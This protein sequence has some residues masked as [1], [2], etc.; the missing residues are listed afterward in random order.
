MIKGLISKINTINLFLVF[1]LVNS[2]CNLNN[3][4]NSS[5]KIR[6]GYLLNITHAVPMILLEQSDFKD[7]L[8]TYHFSAG[9]YLLNNLLTKNLDLAFIGPGPYLTAIDKGFKLKLLGAYAYGANVFVIS[10]DVLDKSKDHIK[11][12]KIAIPQF[13]NTQDLLAKLYL[14]DLAQDFYAI[15]PAE[16]EFAFHNKSIDATLVTEPWGSMLLDKGYVDGAKIF[17][18]KLKQINQYPTTLLVVREEYYE[19][20]KELVDEFTKESIN[21]LRKLAVVKNQQE[22]APLIQRHFKDKVKKDIPLKSIENNLK[23]IVFDEN[24]NLDFFLKQLE[25]TAYKAHYLK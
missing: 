19:A 11:D 13:G 14:K 23:T 7:K 25:Q 16:L 9:G 21:V 1:I 6:M 20:N 4:V 18:H 17:P 2:S 24:N 22:L 10:K 8:E 12:L 15:S 3:Q 5:S